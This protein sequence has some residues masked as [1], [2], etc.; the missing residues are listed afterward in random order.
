[1]NSLVRANR[2]SGHI[3]V[4][5]KA[6]EKDRQLSE[7]WMLGVSCS[8]SDRTVGGHNVRVVDVEG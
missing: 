5:S 7:G 8:H 1:M 6:R 4:D 3:N 2:G